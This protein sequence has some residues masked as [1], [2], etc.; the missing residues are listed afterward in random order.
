MPKGT[1]ATVRTSPGKEKVSGPC[2]YCGETIR[3]VAKR[4]RYCGASLK[5]RAVEQVSAGW[6][7]DDDTGLDGTRICPW[8]S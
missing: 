2:P 1:S 7:V 8:S 5:V 3:A 6:S 4:C